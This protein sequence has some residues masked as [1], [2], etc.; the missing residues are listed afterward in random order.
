MPS[1][2]ILLVEDNVAHIELIRRSFDKDHEDLKLHVVQSLNDLDNM[3]RDFEP[4]IILTDMNLPDGKGLDLLSRSSQ[5][6]VVVMT[7]FGNEQ[8]AVEAIRQGALDYIVK[9]KQSFSEMPHIV[10]RAL[11][12]WNHIITQQRT[13]KALEQSEARFRAIV[14]YSKVGIFISNTNRQLQFIN[15]EMMRLIGYNENELIGTSLFE[16]FAASHRDAINKLYTKALYSN[17]HDTPSFIEIEFTRKDKQK[18][19]GELLITFHTRS[20]KEPQILG[21]LIDI[22]DRKVAEQR[23][24]DLQLQQEKVNLLQLFIGNVTHDLKTP[25]AII[26]TSLHL[27]ARY[28]DPI[29]QKEKIEIINMQTNR[30]NDLIQNLLALTRLDYNAELNYE[31]LIIEDIIRNISLQFYAIVEKKQLQLHF[32]FDNM[33][34]LLSIDH[35]EMTQALFNI[36]ENAINYTPIGGQIIVRTIKQEMRYLIQIEDTGIGID[37]GDLSQIFNRFYRSEEAKASISSGSGIGL[38][39]VKRV[40]EMHDGNIIVES[41]LGKGTKFV[42]SL[43]IPALDSSL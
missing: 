12:E 1:Q 3:L 25:L 17:H 33:P 19:Y 6:P 2:N 15:R 4:D 20:A 27:L 40:I 24:L 35:R 22:T 16:L 34:P 18:R 5:V 9:S 29:K 42:I 8:I 26:K 28:S 14:D 38:A 7:S 39:I 43:P 23:K 31:F 41:D 37:K 10:R 30:L 13:Q 36:I 21:Q 32:D 11:R